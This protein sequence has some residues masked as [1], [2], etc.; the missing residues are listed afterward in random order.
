MCVGGREGVRALLESH[1]ICSPLNDFRNPGG[2]LNTFYNNVHLH[3][4]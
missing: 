1:K 2:K 3:L 4:L